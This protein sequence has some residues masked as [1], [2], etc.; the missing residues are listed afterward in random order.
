MISYIVILL[1][2]PKKHIHIIFVCN[3][4]YKDFL[5]SFQRPYG[6]AIFK[7]AKR[8]VFI[9]F[10][11]LPYMLNMQNILL[12]FIQSDNMGESVKIYVDDLHTLLTSFHLQI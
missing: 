9:R 8:L 7:Y 4:R 6:T 3:I 5:A 10:L 11:G 12:R 1:L 2:H